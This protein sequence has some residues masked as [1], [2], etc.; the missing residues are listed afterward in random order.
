MLQTIR[1][2]KT[3]AVEVPIIWNDLLELVSLLILD[4]KLSQ[5]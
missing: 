2:F 5:L 1:H 3:F 4:Q